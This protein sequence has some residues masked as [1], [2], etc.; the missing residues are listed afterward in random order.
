VTCVTETGSI[1]VDRENGTGCIAF[2]CTLGIRNP[3]KFNLHCRDGA[4]PVSL[5]A[6]D[7][8]S[9]EKSDCVLEVEPHY[10]NLSADS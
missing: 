2:L 7:A 5:W 9:R 4:C 6:E 10:L 8:V 3:G 1:T